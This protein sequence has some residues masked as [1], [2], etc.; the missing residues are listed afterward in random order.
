[1]LYLGSDQHLQ[2]V[3]WTEENPKVTISE[4]ESNQIKPK[5]FSKNNVSYVASMEGCGCGFRQEFDFNYP[6]FSE[7]EVKKENQN[8]LHKQLKELLEKE[9]S[10]E[11]FGTWAGG[12][13]ECEVKK[14]IKVDD[15]LKDD[16]YFAENELI[17]IGN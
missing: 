5:H 1:M 11:L 15:L 3:E 16:F 9:I 14:E 8:Q 7:I 10:L 12:E 17:V 2:T 13:E 4:I 6:D